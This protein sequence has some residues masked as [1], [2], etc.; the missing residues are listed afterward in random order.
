VHKA[1]DE[2]PLG[3]A[4]RVRQL[5]LPREKIAAMTGF[6]ALYGALKY[7]APVAQNDNPV[8]RLNSLLKQCR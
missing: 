5:N 6:L 8:A 1:P 4:Q 3:L 7:G 2:G